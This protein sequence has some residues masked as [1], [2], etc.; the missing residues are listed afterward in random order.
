MTNMTIGMESLDEGDGLT[1]GNAAALISQADIRRA[2][3]LISWGLRP[4]ARPQQY[5]EYR[6]LVERYHRDPIFRQAVEAAAGGGG[7]RVLHCG[8]HGIILA[9]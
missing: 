9:A 7:M 5:E 3:R 4:T 6:E 1:H 2:T 8:P